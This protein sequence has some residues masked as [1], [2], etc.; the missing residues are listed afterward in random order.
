MKRTEQVSI[1]ILMLVAF[2]L[3]PTAAL[4]EVERIER[5]N[6]VIEGVPEIPDRVLERLRQYQNTRSAGMQGW[7][8]AW[9]REGGTGFRNSF[10]EE[11]VKNTGGVWVV[12]GRDGGIES[13]LLTSH[14]RDVPLPREVLLAHFTESPPGITR[15]GG[16][17]VNLQG[18]RNRL[19]CRT[20]SQTRP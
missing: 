7:H 15:W 9:R 8:P 18:H 14:S 19:R 11:S 16:H 2:L 1:G 13:R 17:L 20:T 4:G 10:G 6:L 5:G 3:G 12:R